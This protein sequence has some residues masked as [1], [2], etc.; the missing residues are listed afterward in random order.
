MQE[1]EKEKLEQLAA[2][3][4]NGGLSARNEE[5]TKAE[6]IKVLLNNLYNAAGAGIDGIVFTETFQSAMNEYTKQKQAGAEDV[7][8]CKMFFGY[9]K[10]KMQGSKADKLNE[11]NYEQHNER[12]AKMKELIERI[13]K[14]EGVDYKYYK[15]NL[16]YLNKGKILAKL[17]EWNVEEIYSDDVEAIMRLRGPESLEVM[18]ENNQE[19]ALF[20]DDVIFEKQELIASIIDRSY[21]ISKERKLYPLNRCE[22]S[23]KLYME[24]DSDIPKL[25]VLYLENGYI[26]FYKGQEAWDILNN[27]LLGQYL[28][29]A[30]DTVR[31][32]R[33]ILEKINLLAAKE[34]TGENG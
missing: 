10:I 2:E 32:K 5:R 9:Y 8:F 4:A 31:K 18:R 25:F 26:V 33:K 34:V 6:L 13:G 19:I 12:L 28:H 21:A 22:W 1:A 20:F 27:A 16:R 29:L 23:G 14:T 3:L 30:A 7:S 17:R 24:Y 15:N 11:A